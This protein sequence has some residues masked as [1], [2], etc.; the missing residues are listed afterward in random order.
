MAEETTNSLLN[1]D[2]EF[3]DDEFKSDLPTVDNP[4]L[5]SI[6]NESEDYESP[7]EDDT[8]SVIS[9]VQPFKDSGDTTSLSSSDSNRTDRSSR[10][11][12]K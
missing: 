10:S 9:A 8:S 12:Q 1:F 3:D 4:T 2:I 6:L 5:E 7:A 11:R